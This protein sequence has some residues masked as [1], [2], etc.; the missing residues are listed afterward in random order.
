MSEVLE[1]YFDELLF[2]QP[3][4]YRNAAGTEADISVVFEAP[5]QASRPL[6]DEFENLGPVALART[7][8]VFDAS[9]KCRLFVHDV[10]TDEDGTPVVDEDGTE[11]IAE[12]VGIYNIAHVAPDGTGVTTLN[13]SQDATG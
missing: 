11:I 1:T 10:L 4:T 8:D 9:K 7:D 13:L 2:G 3:A 12:G 6:A 5:D